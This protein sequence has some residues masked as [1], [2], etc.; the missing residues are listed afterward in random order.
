MKEH[1][2]ALIDLQAAEHFVVTISGSPPSA[3]Q[4]LHARILRAASAPGRGGAE[5]AYQRPSRSASKQPPARVR[6][7]LKPERR[8]PDSSPVIANRPPSSRFASP[9]TVSLPTG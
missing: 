9:I 8:Q 1:P 4:R 3:G 5:L 2:S 7:F 6:L